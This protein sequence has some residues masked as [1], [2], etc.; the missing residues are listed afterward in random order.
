MEHLVAPLA[1]P[2]PSKDQIETIVNEL[3]AEKTSLRPQ[4][5]KPVIDAAPLSHPAP[6]LSS[7]RPV[8]AP[9]DEPVPAANPAPL[10]GLLPLELNLSENALIV[11]EKRYLQK[12]NRGN[13]VETPAELFK[14]VSRH[15]ASAEL[16]F[17]QKADVAEWED[18][19]YR[20]MTSLDFL[21][22]SPT[23]MNA[24]RELGQ[25]SACFVLP[26]E[27]SMESIFDAV[28]Y[29]ALI[30]KSG[31]GTGFSFSRIRPKQD[32]VGS[33]GGVASGPVSFMRA[34]DVATDV[35]KQGG[36]RRGANM[37][38]LN[39]DHPDILEF[40]SSKEDP[41]GLHQF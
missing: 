20:L 3:L 39:I 11:L 38:I 34:F 30:H 17:D 33:T 24:G 32:R 35:I 12:D 25:L 29:T 31:G 28:K 41:P 2:P 4:V 8:P 23:L 15:I 14:R 18:R 36:M 5:E 37:G 7:V 26:V 1:T 40:I 19:F 21:P 16:V 10:S 6:V 27:D 22:N 13:I 9:L